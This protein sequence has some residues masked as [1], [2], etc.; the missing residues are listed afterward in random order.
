MSLLQPRRPSMT[1]AL[2]TSVSLQVICFIISVTLVV[3]HGILLT[4][5]GHLPELLRIYS[6]RPRGIVTTILPR[7]AMLAV[8]VTTGL[9][10]ATQTTRTTRGTSTSIRV[11]G[12]GTTTTVA[13]ASPCAPSQKNKFYILFLSA[14]K[15]STLALFREGEVLKLRKL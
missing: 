14:Y 3:A 8:T 2:R 6:F 9:H 11:T 13:T 12:T 5:A 7:W 1:H 4:K 10:L 15:K